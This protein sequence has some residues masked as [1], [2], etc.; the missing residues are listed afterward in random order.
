MVQPTALTAQFLAAANP[1][2]ARHLMRFFKTGEG[3][4]DYGDQFLG[5]P[6]PTTRVC[7][8]RPSATPLSAW[9]PPSAKNGWG[10]NDSRDHYYRER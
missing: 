8:E 9:N 1:E 4:Y 7:R 6:V 3:Q 10:N 5:L 2:K